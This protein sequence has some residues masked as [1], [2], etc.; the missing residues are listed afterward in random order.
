MVSHAINGGAERAKT[1]LNS[2][3]SEEVRAIPD[4][5]LCLRF[6]VAVKIEMEWLHT[7]SVQLADSTDVG[8]GGRPRPWGLQQVNF[9]CVRLLFRS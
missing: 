1:G 4:Q 7:D 5:K 8:V 9:N 3:E 6:S 2:V